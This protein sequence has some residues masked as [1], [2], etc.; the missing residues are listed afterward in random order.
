MTVNWKNSNG[1]NAYHN[2]SKTSLL[3]IKKGNPDVNIVEEK[4]GNSQIFTA[5]REYGLT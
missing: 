2:L 5:I 3:L 4:H 1:F